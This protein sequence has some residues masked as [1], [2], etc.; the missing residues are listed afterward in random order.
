[1]S[2]HFLGCPAQVS[3]TH[4]RLLLLWDRSNGLPERRITG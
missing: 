3:L 1:V 4:G 2:N